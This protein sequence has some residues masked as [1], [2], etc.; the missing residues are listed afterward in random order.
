MKRAQ[1]VHNSP[2]QGTRCELL[3]HLRGPMVRQKINR[4]VAREFYERTRQEQQE[5]Y[6]KPAMLHGGLQ[7]ALPR[8]TQ[9][10]IVRWSLQQ[11]SSCDV[12]AQKAVANLPRVTSEFTS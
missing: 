5:R 8:P 7:K 6:Y 3:D 4:C 2:R 1:R 11:L 10:T 9:S 12:P